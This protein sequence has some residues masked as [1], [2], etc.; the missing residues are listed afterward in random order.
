MAIMIPDEFDG[1]SKGE[2]RLFSQ[3]QELP[4]DVIVYYNPRIK[5]REPDFVV[6]APAIGVVVIEVK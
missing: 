2:Q 5:Q 4:D 1:T 3:L 6:I